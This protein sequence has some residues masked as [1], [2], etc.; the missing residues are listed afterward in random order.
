MILTVLETAEAAHNLACEDV[1]L[2]GAKSRLILW[3]N[4]S[5]VIIG[6]HQNARAEVDAE[7]AASNGIRVVRRITGGGAV[8][9]DLGNVNFSVIKP[10][11]GVI[12]DI[13]DLAAPVL[14]FLTS[15][16]VPAEPKGR[17][18]FLVHG[19]KVSGTARTVRDNAVLC[20]GTVLFDTDIGVMARVLTVGGDKYEGRGIASVKSRVANLAEF[21]PQMDAEG[22]W[23]LAKKYFSGIYATGNMSAAETAAAES[24]A[25]SKYENWEWN[26]GSSPKY[27]FTK[28]AR[29]EAGTISVYMDVSQGVINAVKIH[30]DFFSSGE[31]SRLEGAFAGARHDEASMREAVKGVTVSD[32]ITGLT[33]PQLLSVMV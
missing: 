2:A 27:T 10:Y 7:Y 23:S 8:Y 6:R 11:E 29:F 1:L 14:E 21:L 16:G 9:H 3:R 22:F 31:L 15:L 19:R 20:H 28:T 5:A 33:G 12:D 4:A 24:L 30:G 13:A 32:Y 17:N 18:D 26:F 25:K